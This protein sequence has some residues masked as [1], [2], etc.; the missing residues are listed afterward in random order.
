MM[1]ND[2][3][4]PKPRAKPAVAKTKPKKEEEAEEIK[5]R[6]IPFDPNSLET[7]EDRKSL[8]PGENMGSTLLTFCC[9]ISDQTP[10]RN[11]DRRR[12]TRKWRAATWPFRRP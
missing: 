2:E 12:S 9:G 1:M 4:P 6:V 7:D 10:R 3:P 11:R 8:R 5:L